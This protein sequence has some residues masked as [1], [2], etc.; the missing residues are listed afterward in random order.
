MLALFSPVQARASLFEY[1]GFSP[2]AVA[3]SGALTAEAND[4]SAVFYNP[5]MLV[6]SDEVNV[7]VAF[8]LTRTDAWV[9]PRS[10][11]KALD[12][13]YC[14]PDGAA[15]G[16]DLGLL[17]PLGGKLKNRLAVGVGMHLP[18]N[19][20]VAI[21]SADPKRPFWYQWHNSPDRLVVF[22]GAGAR[23]TDH[24]TLGLG[25]QMLGDLT[26]TGADVRV[27]LFSKQATHREVRSD[28]AAAIS[29]NAGLYWQALPELRLG[30][31]WR[32]EFKHQYVLPADI[33][34]EGVGLLALQVSGYNH[35]TPHSIN[36]GAAWDPSVDLT[37]AV[38]LSYQVWST[39]PS[40]YTRIHV[41]LSGETLAALGL[42]EAMDL[43]TLET[44]AP[45]GFE[46]TLS[47]RAGMEYRL[48]ERF[49]ARGGLSFHPTPVPR[50]VQPG[51]NIL[52]SD[53]LGV[54][55]GFGWSFDDPLEVF[56]APLI[57]DVAVRGIWF[58][59]REA[60]KEDT[61]Q[62]PSYD[63]ASRVLGATVAF[64]YNF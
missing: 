38:D 22:L 2:R 42:D 37:L 58:L 33:Y 40:P 55:G 15:M 57:L 56:E 59:P 1:W 31:S 47:V 21:R 64:R 24:V 18:T 43:D 48:S 62:V 44:D 8:D 53:A 26:G 36:L 35:Y 45:P 12:C 32:G 30:L 25:A 29:P 41:D 23:I 27:D 49:A 7:G 10:L 60:I 16:V 9:T 17:V 13:T 50:Q 51:S 54:S 3:M 63:Y 61:D 39:A 14:A 28:L 11:D 34:L 52:D 20:L 46:D 6:L 4:F 19:N 5:A